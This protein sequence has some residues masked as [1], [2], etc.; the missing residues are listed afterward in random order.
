MLARC[1]LDLAIKRTAVETSIGLAALLIDLLDYPT[2]S[3]VI[4]VKAT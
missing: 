2:S 1:L 4:K 3:Q